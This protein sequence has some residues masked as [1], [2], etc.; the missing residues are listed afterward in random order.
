MER[1]WELEQALEA[2]DRAAKAHVTQRRQS[3]SLESI[4]AD[5]ERAEREA[6][7]VTAWTSAPCRSPSTQPPTIQVRQSPHLHID[8][9]MVCVQGDQSE[10]PTTQ[11]TDGEMTPA[12]PAIRVLVQ[13]LTLFL[14]TLQHQPMDI[15]APFSPNAP[16]PSVGGRG[17]LVMGRSGI[18]V[19]GADRPGRKSHEKLTSFNE[20]RWLKLALFSVSFLLF[21][22][23]PSLSLDSRNRLSSVRSPAC[24]RMVAAR[25]TVRTSPP[26]SSCRSGHT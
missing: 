6:A 16:S 4:E 2:Q 9:L 26:C 22:L 12:A 14:P 13:N 18:G 17:L 10:V 5:R 8:H 3:I 15:L 25:S 11:G 24:G 19:S 20:C 7:G 23:S 21:S 1:I